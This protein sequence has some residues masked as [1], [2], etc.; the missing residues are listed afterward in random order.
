[1]IGLEGFDQIDEGFF[2]GGKLI[3]GEQGTEFIVYFIHTCGIKLLS[4]H[5]MNI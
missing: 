1:L 3:A 5:S 2:P 4:T